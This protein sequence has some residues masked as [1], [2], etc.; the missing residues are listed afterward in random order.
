MNSNKIYFIQSKNIH[1]QR[2]CWVVSS[3][4]ADQAQKM[5]FKEGWLSKAREEIISCQWIPDMVD[6][7]DL[8]DGVPYIK[9]HN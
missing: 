3:P 2:Q 8:Y 5:L 6:T 7:F 4:C 1:G 9:V